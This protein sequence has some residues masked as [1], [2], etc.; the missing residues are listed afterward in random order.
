MDFAFVKRLHFC[1]VQKLLMKTRDPDSDEKACRARFAHAPFVGAFRSFAP[2]NASAVYT[3]NKRSLANI[4]CVGFVFLRWPKFRKQMLNN[5]IGRF[6][7][8]ELKRSS[9]CP[10]PEC[11]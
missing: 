1:S 4:V 7:C 3:K 2:P 9:A 5:T 6:D 11:F 10:N 8:G